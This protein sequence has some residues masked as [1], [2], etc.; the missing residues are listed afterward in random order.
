MSKNKFQKCIYLDEET[1]VMCEVLMHEQYMNLS[2][3]VRRM[4]RN[5]H[6]KYRHEEVISNDD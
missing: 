1:Y 3:F 2:A 5:A 6:D 4:I